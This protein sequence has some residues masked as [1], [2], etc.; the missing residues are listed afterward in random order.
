MTA[1]RVRR[2]QLPIAYRDR[3]DRVWS[4]SEIAVLKVVSPAID[5][6]NVARD[7]VRAGG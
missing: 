6:P 5:G 4:V 7:P 1:A 2:Q 3:H